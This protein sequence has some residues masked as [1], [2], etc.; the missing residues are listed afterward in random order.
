[1][2][3]EV[4]EVNLLLCKLINVDLLRTITDITT[5]K[6]VC[7]SNCLPIDTLDLVLDF[8]VLRGVVGSSSFLSCPC[9][10]IMKL[11]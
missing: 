8:P 6:G 1:M 11:A 10:L 4:N 2:R 7:A 3:K 9:F 5:P